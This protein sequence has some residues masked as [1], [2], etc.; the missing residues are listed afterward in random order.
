[1]DITTIIAALKEQNPELELTELET[2]IGQ[3]QNTPEQLQQL[4]S[5]VQEKDEELNRLRTH[6]QELLDEKARLKAQLEGTQ[7]LDPDKI[8]QE[9]TQSVQE[10]ATQEIR[11]LQQQIESLKQQTTR[12]NLDR[13]V[14]QALSE[15]GFEQPEM[16]LQL[17]R[18]RWELDGE[19]NPVYTHGAFRGSMGEGVQRLGD[20]TQFEIFCRQSKKEKQGGSSTRGAK[21]TTL[22]QERFGGLNPFVFGEHYSMEKQRELFLTDKELA[23]RLKAEAAEKNKNKR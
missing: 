3:I 12:L 16:V 1:M 6:N 7:K 19:D 11:T 8:R 9:A 4:Q 10:K 2:A 18:D 23:L 17:S 20:D 22:P 5:S 14:V 13:V 15:A 21:A